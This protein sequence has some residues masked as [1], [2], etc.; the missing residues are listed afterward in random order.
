MED[1]IEIGRM[2]VR[3]M[4]ELKGISNVDDMYADHAQSVEA[5]VPP[6]RTVRIAKSKAAIKAKR[7]NWLSS[8][9]VHRLDADG[10]FVHPPNR[11]GVRFEVDVTQK[12]TGR[13]MTLREIAIYS[14]EGGKIVTEEFFMQPK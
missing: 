4:R 7:E 8:F 1:L 3:Q 10:P 2:F 5:V 12:T 6:D 11:F 14:V 13:R 9:K